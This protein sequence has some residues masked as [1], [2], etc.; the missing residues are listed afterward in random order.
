MK[1][2]LILFIAFLATICIAP[3]ADWYH[4]RLQTTGVTTNDSGGLAKAAISNKRIIENVAALNSVP[5]SELVLVFNRTNG[6]VMVVERD[7]GAIISPVFTMESSFALSNTN[8]G[9]A[10]F[11]AHLSNGQGNWDGTAVGS[12]IVRKN[13]AGSET[14][15]RMSGK[16]HISF[17]GI[18]YRSEIHTGVFSTGAPFTPR[19][20]VL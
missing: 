13:Q 6:Q 19:R 3:A 10:E 11:L 15:F 2:P 16:I 9:R 20:R 7:L 14:A 4:I 17:P 1:L 5:A 18:N 12:V 8:S